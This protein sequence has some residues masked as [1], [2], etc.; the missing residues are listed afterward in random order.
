MAKKGGGGTFNY[1]GGDGSASQRCFNCGKEGC[2]VKKCDKPLNK[3]LI[4][5][6][7][8]KYY[9]TKNKAQGQSASG[10]GDRNKKGD[11]KRKEKHADPVVSQR[12]KWTA[13]GIQ[14][15]DN[16]LKVNCKEC[17]LNSIYSLAFTLCG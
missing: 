14:L 10:G 15:V 7:C 12:K 9:A 2:V 6:N 1:S 5:K 17:G 4:K 11:R 16:V 8:E 3:E 13:A